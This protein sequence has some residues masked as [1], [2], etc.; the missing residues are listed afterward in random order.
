AVPP[1]RRLADAPLGRAFALVGRA[2]RV[3]A[4]RR[5]GWSLGD[6]D[7]GR[8]QQAVV[9]HITGL[10]YLD[11][12]ARRD[13]AAFSLEDRL[14]KI[15]VEALTLWVDALQPVPLERVEQLALGRHE[16]FQKAAH[17]LIADLAFRQAFERPAQ[18]VDR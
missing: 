6:P 10:Q 7:H 4:F 13:I 9:Q 18:I 3:A 17:S 11:D 2:V 15:V 1:T 16:A 14:V 12:R 8:P 5:G